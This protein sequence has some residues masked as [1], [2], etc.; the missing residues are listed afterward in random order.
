MKVILVR[1]PVRIDF[2]GGWTDVPP[3]ADEKGGTVVNAT[4]N[5]FVEGKFITDDQDRISVEYRS[6]IPASSGLGTSATMNV[7]WLKLIN[8][9]LDSANVAEK[10]YW[11][12]KL[13]GIAGGIK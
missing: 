5:K 4:I 12:E 1:A 10:S 3:Y 6:D 7:V 13:L 9:D 8:N 2:A 11:L